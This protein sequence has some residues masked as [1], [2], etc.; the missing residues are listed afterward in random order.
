MARKELMFALIAQDKA[1]HQ[2]YGARIAT[3]VAIVTMVTCVALF[4]STVQGPRVGMLYAALAGA[5][6]AMCAGLVKEVL[7]KR[8]NAAAEVFDLPQTHSVE[9]ADV[10]ATIV[11]GVTTMLP[12]LLI[13]VTK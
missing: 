12:L 3:G 10:M 9:K 6:A 5:A 13:A 8:A 1:N 2:V 11:G 7:D 4:P